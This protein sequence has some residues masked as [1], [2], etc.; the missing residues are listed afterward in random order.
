MNCC[1]KCF[2]PLEI[3]S[4]IKSLDKIG[5]C[6][7][8]HSEDV[9]IYNLKEDERLDSKFNDILS[10]FRLRAE[11]PEEFPPQKLF[12]IKDEFSKNWNIFNGLTS[13]QIYLL[14]KHLL[15][16]NYPEKISLLN[17]TVG[18]LEHMNRDYLEDES[19]LKNY[20]WEEFIQYIKHKNRFHSNHINY[21]ILKIYLEGLAT[22]INKG[23]IFYRGRIFNDG[24]LDLEKLGAPSIKHAR[25]GRANSEGI[26]H[27]YLASDIETV[28]KEVRPSTSDNIFIGR[29]PLT[30]DIKVIDFRKLKKI[31][32]FE[33]EDPAMYAINIDNF[34]KM[35]KEI[36]KPVRSGDSKLDY[37]PTQFIVDYIK[38]LN[39]FEQHDYEGIVFESTLSTRGYNLMLFEPSSLICNRIFKKTISDVSYNHIDNDE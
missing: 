6:N 33:F 17:N 11:L 12:M 25:A 34:N 16:E 28:I 15:E 4:M 7:I 21:K 2:L 37:L 9:Y 14:L 32:V 31:S 18:I 29:F 24:E 22:T 30:A 8:C 1:E 23:E 26:S 36:S 27:L 10:I 13:E 3:K 19:L 38:S 20:S 5:N 39:D 35:S